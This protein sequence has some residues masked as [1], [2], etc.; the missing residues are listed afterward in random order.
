MAPAV[1][2]VAARA[3][4]AG[5][6]SPGCAFAVLLYLSVLLHE[7]SHALMAQRYGL[8]VALDQLHF[9]G[10]VTAIE[11]EARTPGRSS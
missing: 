5:S 4:R 7:V 10:G 2:Q 6:T 11:G 8:P 3:R 9:L 1:E